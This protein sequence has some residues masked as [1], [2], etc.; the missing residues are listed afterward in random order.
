[1][2]KTA[3]PV[4]IK[5][6]A[7]DG[8]KPVHVLAAL[9]VTVIGNDELYGVGGDGTSAVP[10]KTPELLKEMPVGRAAVG[11]PVPIDQVYPMPV[12]PKADMAKP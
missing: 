8:Y 1:M 5:N 11:E 3:G 9:S 6:R 2:F 4:W 12:P 10:E 7:P